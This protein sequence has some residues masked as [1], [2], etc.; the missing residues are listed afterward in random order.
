VRDSHKRTKFKE[1]RKYIHAFT[2]IL[3]FYCS[4]F[5]SLMAILGGKERKMNSRVLLS[6]SFI[7]EYVGLLTGNNIHW[8]P[9]MI[10]DYHR[11]V[12]RLIQITQITSV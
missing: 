2:G 10:K 8:I 9:R 3:K 1:R 4:T 6:I 5:A 12:I 7:V 11:V